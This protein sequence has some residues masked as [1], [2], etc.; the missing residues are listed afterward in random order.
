MAGR[1]S[2]GSSTATCVTRKSPTFRDVVRPFNAKSQAVRAVLVN[3]F[4][5]SRERC[6]LRMPAEM[7][8]A[9]L[10][11]GTDLEFGQSIYEP[12]GIAQMEPLAAGAVCVVSNVCG[13]VGFAERA[14]AGHN[15]PNMVVADYITLPQYWPLRNPWDALWIDDRVRQRHRRTRNSHIAAQQIFERLPQ[16]NTGMAALLES[17]QAVAGRMSWDVVVTDYL[18]PALAKL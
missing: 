15:F 2:T 4:G 8:F 12:F 10:R 1:W 18:L 7:T 6:G 13:C 11:A 14:A 3:Q 5:W 16:D 17:G 9:D